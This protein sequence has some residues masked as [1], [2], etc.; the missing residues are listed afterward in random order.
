MTSSGAKSEQIIAAHFKTI[1]LQFSYFLMVPN[2]QTALIILKTYDQQFALTTKKSLYIIFK[3]VAHTGLRRTTDLS[4][5]IKV[6]LV[7][8]LLPADTHRHSQPTALRGHKVVS[9]DN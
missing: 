2:I 3:N 4:I 8:Q 6:C 1:F 5:N 7:Q 9:N